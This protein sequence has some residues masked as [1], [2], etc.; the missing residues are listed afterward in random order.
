MG[1]NAFVGRC[2]VH[3]TEMNY[4]VADN[5]IIYADDVSNASTAFAAVV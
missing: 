5:T 1:T 2:A 4:A 3:S